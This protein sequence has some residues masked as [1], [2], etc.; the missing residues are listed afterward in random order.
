VRFRI[1]IEVRERDEETGEVSV[2]G[3]LNK[4]EVSYLLQFAINALMAL[5]TE[6]DLKSEPDEL[7][8]IRFK[9]PKGTTIN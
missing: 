9:L 3:F 4:N 7:E 1:K 8:K 6:I 2:S 5:G